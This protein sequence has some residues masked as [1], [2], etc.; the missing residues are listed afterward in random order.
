MSEKYF[1]RNHIN[2]SSSSSSIHNNNYNNNHDGDNDDDDDDDDDNNNNNKIIIMLII[3][4][5]EEKLTALHERIAKQIDNISNREDIPKW[6]TL[7]K[8][9]F[10]KKA[11]VKKMLL[12]ITYQYRASLKCGS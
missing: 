7:G 11:L 1:T 4:V 8:R 3:I 6:M 2:N 9:V 12:I 5:I 10:F